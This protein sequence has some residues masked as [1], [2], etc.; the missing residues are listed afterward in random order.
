[1]DLNEFIKRTSKNMVKYQM[2]ELRPRIQC[3]DGFVVSV[4]A[5]ATHYCRPRDNNGVFYTAVECGFPSELPPDSWMEYAEQDDTPLDTV[6]CW[7]PFE[8]VAETIEEH[9][10]IDIGATF[11]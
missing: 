4:Q 7:I 5:S 11:G 10:G 6:Y 9:G 8:L 3:A 1:M 2:L